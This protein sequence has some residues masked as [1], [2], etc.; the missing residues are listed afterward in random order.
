MS[1]RHFLLITIFLAGAALHASPAEPEAKERR[2]PKKSILNTFGKAV[3]SA[4]MLAAFGY[5]GWKMT[6]D[7]KNT[8]SLFRNVQFNQEYFRNNGPEMAKQGFATTACWLVTLHWLRST[9]INTGELLKL[10]GEEPL[11]E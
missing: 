1:K 10:I 7:C 9:L 11:K 2:H 8:R 3:G 6:S 5:A 4:S